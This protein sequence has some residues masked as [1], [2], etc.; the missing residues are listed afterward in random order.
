M[1]REDLIRYIELF[2]AEILSIYKGEIL[3]DIR[4][5]SSFF[6]IFTGK[7]RQE[8]IERLEYLKEKV[9]LIDPEKIE[10]DK[11]DVEA[12]KVK[13]LFGEVVTYFF[14]VCNAQIDFQE[15][16]IRKESKEPITVA[17]M[18]NISSEL[19]KNNVGMQDSIKAI[20]D[21]MI[22]QGVEK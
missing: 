8:T 14:G 2:E 10:I 9:I 13:E 12:A 22:K 4:K 3:K 1:G 5:Q 20:R 19:T 15:F 18:N 21:I 11:E 7:H 16:L 6:S 17:E